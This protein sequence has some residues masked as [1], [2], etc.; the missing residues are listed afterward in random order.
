MA[1]KELKVIYKPRADRQIFSLMLY[2]TQKGYPDTAIQFYNELYDFGDS[3]GIFPEK[4]TISRHE[5][6]R[7]RNLRCAPY[8]NYI[9]IYKVSRNKLVIYNIV[10][11]SA[12]H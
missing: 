5:K 8:K 9:F 10:H 6:F 11:G 4:Y 2:I 7:K 3:L 1:A 12:I